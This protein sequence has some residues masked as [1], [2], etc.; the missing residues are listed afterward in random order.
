M[1]DCYLMPGERLKRTL[2]ITKSGGGNLTVDNIDFYVSF[3]TNGGQSN[4][5]GDYDATSKPGG[6]PAHDAFAIKS[7]TG[8]LFPSGMPGIGT[9]GNGQGLHLQSAG[10]ADF[11]DQNAGMDALLGE[12]CAGRGSWDTGGGSANTKYCND[13]DGITCPAA[14]GATNFTKWTAEHLWSASE[15]AGRKNAM[16]ST[17]KATLRKALQC[18]WADAAPA[19]RYLAAF[20][21]GYLGEDSGARSFLEGIVKNGSDDDKVAAEASLMLMGNAADHTKYL[22]DVTACADPSND[23]YTSSVCAGALGIV[24]KNDAVVTNVL[25]ADA[26][27]ICPGDCDGGA[28]PGPFFASHILAIVSWDRRGWA[29]NGD[30]TGD[31]SYFAGVV[32]DTTPPQAPTNVKCTAQQPPSAGDIQVQWSPVTLDVNSKPESSVS[33]VVYQDTAAHAGCTK[34][35]DPGCNYA[36]SDKVSNTYDTPSTLDGTKTYYF[37]VTAVDAAKNESAFSAE[38][39]C[40]P[41]YP[42]TAKLSC[43]PL[44]G[45]VPPTLNVTCDAVDSDDPNGKSDI[46]SYSF[47]LDS[48]APV[49]GAATT[50]SYSFDAAGGHTVLLTVTDSTGLKATD[51]N[52]LTV[53]SGG[54]QPP[55]AKASANPTTGDAP[56]DVTFDS[57]GS[58][59]ADSPP[60]SFSWNF[61]DGSPADTTAKPTH[62]Y[63]SA[64]TYNAVLT[65]TDSGSPPASS[66]AGVS[67]V[68]KGNRPPDVSSASASPLS[69]QPPLTVTFDATGVTD[70]DGDTVSVKW[71]FGDSAT[72]TKMSDTHT[73]ATTGS[74]AVVLTATD[75]R[76]PPLSAK[77][78]F[79]ISVGAVNR[80][81]DCSAATVTPLSGP[82]PLA[83]HMNA[84]PCVDPD[85]NHLTYRWNVP[86]SLITNDVIF[87]TAV[88]DYTFD[89][90]KAQ[91]L[92]NRTA[93]VQLTATDDGSPPM[94][95]TEEYTVVIGKGSGTGDGGT[96]VTGD[97][98]TVTPFGPDSTV[99]SGC[100]CT[101][102]GAAPGAGLFLLALALLR[103]RR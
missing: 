50:K 29:P 80:P 33:Y 16:D 77:T 91:A 88:A 25:L 5:Y 84:T 38:V 85:G 101:T 46:A 9:T 97:G 100:G 30:D 70:P 60:I 62:T 82:A 99:G 24:D 53:T 31:P 27:W 19:A 17:R 45:N 36:H 8:T 63:A 47:Q 55:V 44:T 75:D 52:S 22:A 43:T 66:T 11:S 64:G 1:G 39:H 76:T 13:T 93:V 68:V 74:Y 103:R 81:P 6:S 2:T 42:P 89:E 21:L 35:A 18:G 94:Q 54:N 83:I 78:N 87:N 3:G 28:D 26:R 48:S 37:R 95:V 71:D 90:A 58:S 69:G 67:V 73:Y 59:D 102:G 98:G 79:T 57:T 61:G 20:A 15:L 40:V 14:V 10:V 92:V 23:V 56:L 32:V 72:S 41:I 96:P 86:T 7:T 51:T 49:S 12:Y 65:V 4:M 34:P